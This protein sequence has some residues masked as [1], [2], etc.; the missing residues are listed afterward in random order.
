L[1]EAETRSAEQ[2]TKARRRCER[3]WRTWFVAVKVII[4]TGL[5]RKQLWAIYKNGKMLS[6]GGATRN[7]RKERR[8]GRLPSKST[9]G[10]NQAVGAE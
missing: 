8:N 2:E 4:A 9:V 10:T 3:Q 5:F 6:R 1:G 7:K